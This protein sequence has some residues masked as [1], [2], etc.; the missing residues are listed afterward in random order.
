MSSIVGSIKD[1]ND[2]F[3]DDLKQGLDSSLF[4]NIREE[5][6]D[7]FNR[8]VG[9]V[10]NNKDNEKLGRCQIRVYGLFSSPEIPDADLPWAFP[11]MQFIGSKKGSFIIPPIGA[12]VLVTFDKGD[13]YLPRYSTKVIDK[14]NLPIRRNKNYPNNMVFFET[15]NGDYFEIDRE[16][17]MVSFNHKSG[18]SIKIYNN[19]NVEINSKGELITI[20]GAKNCN[21][22][23]T[24]STNL[25]G[26]MHVLYSTDGL[27]PLDAEGRPLLGVAV[28]ESVT[29]GL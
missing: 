8:F 23:G 20:T 1:I 12:I 19:G 26:N 11:D 22:Y 24:E 17:S 14:N 25:G 7:Y 9:K 13:I 27:V 5:T 28:S 15:D 2:R 29:V 4:E 6:V 16:T 18:T 10:V 21:V 3:R